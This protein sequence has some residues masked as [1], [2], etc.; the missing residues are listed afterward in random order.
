MT[1]DIWLVA[2]FMLVALMVASFL[3]GI[4]VAD[5]ISARRNERHRYSP[6]PIRHPAH[7]RSTCKRPCCVR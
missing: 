5:A 4:M 1:G 6:P 2:L 7:D 3:V